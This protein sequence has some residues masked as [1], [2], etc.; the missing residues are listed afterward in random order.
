LM[1]LQ[2]VLVV[3]TAT[4]LERSRF[5]YGLRAVGQNDRLAA[6]SG[7]DPHRL[8]RA[9]YAL[10]ALF[11]AWTGGVAA[12]W[13]SYVS[14]SDVFGSAI[15]FQAVVMALVGG[16]GTPLGPVVGAGF[17]TLLSE[18]LGTRFVYYYLIA[19]GLVI[20]GISILAPAGLAGLMRGRQ[21]VGS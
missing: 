18:F 6:A 11:T 4:W 16:L 17:L 5:G 14:A 12:Y 2:M 8:K 15:T 21:G 3:S 13:L 10:S 20:M 9:I 7:V 1:L 19:M